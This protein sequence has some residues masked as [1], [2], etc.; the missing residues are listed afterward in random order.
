MGWF[1]RK[2]NETSHSSVWETCKRCPNRTTSGHLFAANNCI[3]RAESKF[4]ELAQHFLD[5][6]DYDNVEFHYK[7]VHFYTYVDSNVIVCCGEATTKGTVVGEYNHEPTK[8]EVDHHILVISYKVEGGWWRSK[9]EHIILD[10]QKSFNTDRWD[11][12]DDL[13]IEAYEDQAIG[14]ISI[15]TQKFYKGAEF[16][17]VIE[18]MWDES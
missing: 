8:T 4:D 2:K 12:I 13:L 14:K 11:K 6:Y 16:W 17:Q 5:R 10:D 1:S 9:W 7:R 15:K 18:G 3:K